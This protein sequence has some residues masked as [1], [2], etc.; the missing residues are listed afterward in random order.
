MREIMSNII[1][2]CKKSKGDKMDDIELW[3]FILWLY[4]TIAAVIYL[5]YFYRFK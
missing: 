4:I 5:V 3:F 2:W 1:K